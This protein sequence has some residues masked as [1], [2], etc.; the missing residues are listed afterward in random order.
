MPCSTVATGLVVGALMPGAVT[1]KR[2]GRTRVTLVI[3]FEWLKGQTP[4]GQGAR[5]GAATVAYARAV[6]SVP[7]VP[8]V[9]F[10]PFCPFVPGRP[11]GPRLDFLFLAVPATWSSCLDT[12][13]FTRSRRDGPPSAGETT[14]KPVSTSAT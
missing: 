9:P 12:S 3:P 14:T 13:C 10:V 5:V 7:L 6:P 2:P 1:Q 11:W 4:P 8:F